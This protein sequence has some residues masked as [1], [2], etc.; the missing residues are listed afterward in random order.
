[1]KYGYYPGCSLEGI[2]VEYNH[3][4]RSL[5]AALEVTIEDLPDWICC[6][7]LAAPSISRLLGVATPLWNVAKAKQEG[8]EQLVAPCSACVY[9]FKN[10]E[11]QVNTNSELMTEVESVLNM[12]LNDLPRTVHPLEILVNDGFEGRIKSG[13]RQD[14]SELKVVCYYGCHISRPA[15]V[16]QFDDPEDPQTMDLLLSSAGVQT[17]EW[18]RK[19]DCCGAHFSLIKPDIVI[20]LCAELVESA[21]EVGADAIV[22]ACPMCHANLDTRQEKIADK[23][24]QP[25]NIPILYF[26]QVL[27]YALGIAPN[28]LGL[29]KHIVDPLPL[30]L[31]KCQSRSTGYP[32]LQ[33][34]SA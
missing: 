16:M 21:L 2:S 34:V 25:I 28:L 1:M 26:S 12:P 17:L 27:G 4:M 13:V 33:E 22:V 24:G 29:M 20:D 23:L 30:M 10:A 6:G 32:S 15:D 14:L 18:S 5:F 8:F 3:S 19:V 11:K 7:T 9:H 31:E